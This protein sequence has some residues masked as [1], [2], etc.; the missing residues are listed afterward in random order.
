VIGAMK[1]RFAPSII[2]WLFG[3]ETKRYVQFLCVT[4]V[5]KCDPLVIGLG[6]WSL[7]QKLILVKYAVILNGG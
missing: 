5:E 3:L 1:K 6:L 7:D 2:G 4:N